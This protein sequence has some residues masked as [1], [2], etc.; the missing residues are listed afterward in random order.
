[1]VSN[2][3]WARNS[4]GISKLIFNRRSLKREL[5]VVVSKKRTEDI[6]RFNVE[7]NGQSK[8]KNWMKTGFSLC[9]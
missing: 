6:L 3:S 1:M 5:V 7:R 2:Y 4:E 8:G 9:P